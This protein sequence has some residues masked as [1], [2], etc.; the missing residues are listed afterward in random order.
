MR[1]RYIMRTMI[2]TL[3]LFAGSVLAQP[4]LSGK[5]KIERQVAEKQAMV[6]AAVAGAA[7]LSDTERAKADEMAKKAIAYLRTQQDKEKGGWRINPQGPTFPAISALAMWGMLMQPG[8][9]A[10]DESIAAGT[11]FLLSLQ[12]ADGGIYDKALPSYNTAIS[13]S[14]LA[15]LP[16]TPELAEHIRKAQDFIRA[17][18]YGE[19]AIEYD[20]LAESAQKV[21]RNHAYYGGV[22]YGNRGRPDLSNLSFAIEAMAASGVPSDDPFFERAMV[23]LQRCQMLEEVNGK[24]V[25]D[26]PYADGSTQGGFIYATAVNKDTIGQGQSFAG[27]VAESLSGPPGLSAAVTLKQKGADGKQVTLK[28]EDIIKR[29]QEAISAST[30]AAFTKT[31]FMV[32]LGPTG[33]GVS[34]NNFEVRAGTTNGTELRFALAKAFSNDLDGV[35]DIKLTPVSAW[36]GISKLRAYGTM[37]YSGFKSYAYAGLKLDDPRVLAARKWITNNYTLAENPGMGTDG[38]YYY[39]MVFGRA[40]HATGEAVIPVR[41]SEGTISPR[42]WQRDLIN[43]LAEL[44]AED[45]SFKAVDDRW[46]ENDPV[47]ITSYS[48]IALQHAIR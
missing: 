15:R 29:V 12:Q 45:G 41:E 2:C 17:L 21:D 43:R 31:E 46:M 28:R 48:L 11:K 23:F 6:D 44:Q 9:D 19:G 36:K 22:G 30:D 7:P 13:L 35:G 47:L 32:V 14:A 24:P 33:D 8:I 37:T 34:V 20:G 38:F 42:N 26:M 18:Q 40:N 10:T 39:L 3:I 25:N 27:E 16:R 5:D 4:D 1:V